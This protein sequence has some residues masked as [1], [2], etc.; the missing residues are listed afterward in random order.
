MALLF[1]ENRWHATDGRGRT[2]NAARGQ[3]YAGTGDII[4]RTPAIANESCIRRCSQFSWV[5]SMLYCLKKI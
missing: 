3:L 4:T 2:L 1:R 5:L